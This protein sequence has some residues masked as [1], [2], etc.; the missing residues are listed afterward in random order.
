[1]KHQG[2]HLYVYVGWNGFIINLDFDWRGKGRNIEFTLFGGSLDGK[3][4]EA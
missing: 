3:W 2:K 1:V 4:S